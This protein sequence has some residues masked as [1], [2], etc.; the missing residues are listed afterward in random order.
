MKPMTYMNRAGDTLQRIRQEAGEDFSVRDL[1]VIA[2]DVNLPLGRMRFRRGGSAGGH[3]GL[4]SIIAALATE[5][6]PRLRLGIGAPATRGDDALTR[7]VLSEFTAAE[8]K[9]VA[10]V[11]EVAAGAVR[12][13]LASDLVYCQN[14]YNGWRSER[15]QAV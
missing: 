4:A 3:N 1:L 15:A 10:E 14:R 9:V 7:W 8:E 11:T 5:E 2:D 13:W 6:V 12:E